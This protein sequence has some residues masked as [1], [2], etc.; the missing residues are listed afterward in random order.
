M[1]LKTRIVK[2]GEVEKSY[3]D[4]ETRKSITQPENRNRELMQSLITSAHIRL[5]IGLP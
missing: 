4:G 1:C 3:A 5:I 2:D